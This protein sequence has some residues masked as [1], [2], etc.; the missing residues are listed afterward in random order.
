MFVHTTGSTYMQRPSSAR[1]NKSSTLAKYHQTPRGKDYGTSKAASAT[2]G[3]VHTLPVVDYTITL[4]INKAFKKS[5]F[6]LEQCMT[7]N[8]P[9]F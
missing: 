9:I 7:Q 2:E 3:S 5:I 4:R 1:P 6:I 8:M